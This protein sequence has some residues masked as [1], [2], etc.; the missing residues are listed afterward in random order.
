MAYSHVR[1]VYYSTFTKKQFGPK[2][3]AG[4]PVDL[5]LEAKVRAQNIIDVIRHVAGEIPV[6]SPDDLRKSGFGVLNVFLAPEFFFRSSMGTKDGSDHYTLVEVQEARAVI[7]E[8]VLSSSAFDDWLLVPGTAV[9]K[10]YKVITRKSGITTN[11]LFNDAWVITRGGSRGRFG[12]TELVCQKQNFAVGDKLEDDLKAMSGPLKNLAA[13]VNRQ[14]LQL[15]NVKIGFEICLDHK[16]GALKNTVKAPPGTLDLHL[17]ISCGMSPVPGNVAART[18]GYVLRC[19][20]DDYER[21]YSRAYKVAPGTGGSGAT[22]SI[23]TLQEIGLPN[24]M[25]LPGKLQLEPL[26]RIDSV[27]FSDLLPLP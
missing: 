17:L 22:G 5:L 27:G 6:P 25:Q 10:N 8:A 3:L 1:Y 16:N 23:P 7:R 19:N 14:I 12:K 24:S 21:P 18:G 4:S 2:G 26:K 15:D 20:G 11:V 9:Y 13:K